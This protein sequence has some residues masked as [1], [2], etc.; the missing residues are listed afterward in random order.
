MLAERVRAAVLAVLARADPATL[1][2]RD[3]RHQIAA[4]LGVAP[5]LVEQ[6]QKKEQIHD[7][8]AE[9]ARSPTVLGWVLTSCGDAGTV[10]A[11][12][13]EAQDPAERPR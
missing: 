3:V 8:L 7:I 13:Q 10:G 12:A 5:D 6:K 2:V 1:T 4:Q 9:V 11:A